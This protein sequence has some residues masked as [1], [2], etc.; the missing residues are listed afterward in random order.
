MTSRTI[1]AR[2]SDAAGWVSRRRR[3]P[4]SLA[5]AAIALALHAVVLYALLQLDGVRSAV[6]AVVPIT[7]SLITPPPPQNV[8][9]EPP[10]LIPPKARPRVQRPQAT[11]SPPVIAAAPEAPAELVVPPPPAPAPLPPI[12][13]PAPV[14]A[15]TSE[16]VDAPPAPPAPPPP[17]TPPSF[18]AAYLN[19]PAPAYPTL[20]RRMG[21]E[22]R[23]VLRVFV[24]E[25]GFPREVQLRTS[26]KHPRLDEAALAAVKRWRF[27]PARR[28]DSPIG[29]W[30]LVPI[31]FSL[32]S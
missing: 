5:G 31:S 23:V 19:N 12:D 3:P 30:V 4:S 7:V 32:R 28:G 10:K 9:K 25:D 11:P 24:T 14:A 20:S 1:G 22:G 26:S 6:I 2:S 29:A 17:L 16:A 18:S 27:V 8:P 21:E 15:R 13:M